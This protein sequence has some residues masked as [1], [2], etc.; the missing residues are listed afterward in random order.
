MPSIESPQIYLT[1]VQH[2]KG[3]NVILHLELNNLQVSSSSEVTSAPDAASINYP[4]RIRYKS[5]LMTGKGSFLC[6]DLLSTD[7]SNFISKYYK[8]K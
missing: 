8:I 5:D 7:H 6:T 1:S 4:T 3:I 2:G